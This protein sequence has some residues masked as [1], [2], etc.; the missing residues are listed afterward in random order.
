MPVDQ[1]CICV[2]FARSL[3][4]EQKKKVFSF[5][6]GHFCYFSKQ[7]FYTFVVIQHVKIKFRSIFKSY[8]KVKV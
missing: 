2:K 7:Q 1:S 4:A 5:S 3:A 6:L 8:E